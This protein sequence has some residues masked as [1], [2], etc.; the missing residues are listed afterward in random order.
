MPF[1]IGFPVASRKCFKVHGVNKGLVKFFKEHV[2]DT[3]WKDAS[4]RNKEREHYHYTGAYRGAACHQC[5]MA[6]EAKRQKKEERKERTRLQRA[7]EKQVRHGSARETARRYDCNA[8]I[9]VIECD[10]MSAML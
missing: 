3:V 8:V 4:S 1:P 5:N 9:D 10:A 2:P 7:A 6:K